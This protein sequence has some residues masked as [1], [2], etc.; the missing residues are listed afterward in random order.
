MNVSLSHDALRQ[1][2]ELIATGSFQDADQVVRAAIARMH[3]DLSAVP[4]TEERLREEI[5]RAIEH[6]DR[7]EYRAFSAKDIGQRGRKILGLP[8]DRP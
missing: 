5:G 6:A 2:E 4:W 3:G 1:V 8:S 7:G